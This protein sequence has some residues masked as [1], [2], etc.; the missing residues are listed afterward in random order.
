MHM[1]G[2]RFAN[3]LTSLNCS[4][5]EMTWKSG[6]DVL[7]FGATK[8]GCIAAEAII[9]FK[10]DLVGNIAFLMKRAG[11]LLSKMRFVS[12]QLDAYISNDVWLKNAKHANEMG[13]KLSDG[14]AKHNSIEIAYPTEANE[15]FAKLPRDIIEHLNSEG[16]IINED[17]LDGKA[18]RFVAAWN[19]QASDVESFLN[20]IT[21]SK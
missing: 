10:K 4:P 18:V 14:L 5:A 17:E 15:V 21:Q 8:N 9:F 12:A 2:A 1:D 19:T 20:S 3:A 13:K 7:S 6:I 11:H 16:Y